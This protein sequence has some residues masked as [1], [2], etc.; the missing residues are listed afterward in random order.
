MAATICSDSACLTRGSLAPCAMSMG[1]RMLP[2]RDSGE[3]DQRK[4]TSVSG[5]PTRRW[6]WATIGAQYGGI[7][8]IRVF[9]F[10]GPTMLTAQQN[11]S[12]VNAA[13]ARAA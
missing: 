11:R 2:A 4:L 3:R 6:N 1:M 7:V 5:L 13:P 10:E 9:R 8:S 12:G